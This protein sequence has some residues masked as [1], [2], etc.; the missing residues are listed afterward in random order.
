MTPL[1]LTG[2]AIMALAVPLMLRRI[3]PNPLYGLRV[4]ATFADPDVWY[5]ANARSGR[6]LLAYGA[7]IVLFTLA[8]APP[9]LAP[10]RFGLWLAVLMLGGAIVLCVS[11]W[12]Y[13]NRLLREKRAGG[14]VTDGRRPGG[15]GSR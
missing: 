4:P 1:L 6:E 8:F 15:T 2:L 13:A 11:G 7:A 5:A 3:P 10:D 9:R 14:G 12:R